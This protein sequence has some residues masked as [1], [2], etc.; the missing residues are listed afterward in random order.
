VTLRIT[1]GEAKGRRLSAFQGSQIRPTSDKVR[2][3]IFNLIG[4]D[5]QGVR[6][7]DLF[8]GTGSLGIE[9]LSRGA[10]RVIFVD[11]SHHSIELVKRNLSLCGYESLGHVLKKDLARG[12]PKRCEMMKGEIDL[13]FTDP[14]YGKGHLPPVLREL[15]DKEILASPSIVVAET[16]KTEALPARLGKLELVKTRIYGDTKIS[17]YYYGHLQ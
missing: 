13:V 1:G 6:V 8:A 14:P 12:L 11:N 10:S 17:L 4:Q 15:S 9:A 3:A 16:S 2:E 7:L 5:A